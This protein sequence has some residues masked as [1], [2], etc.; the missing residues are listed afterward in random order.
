MKT[1]VLQQQ[2]QEKT[3]FCQKDWNNEI[4]MQQSKLLERVLQ[5]STEENSS[6]ISFTPETVAN[7]VSE[8]TYNLEVGIIFQEIWDF[9]K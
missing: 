6:T 9:Q 3:C 7:S 4:L 8:F 5:K 2:Q 1:L